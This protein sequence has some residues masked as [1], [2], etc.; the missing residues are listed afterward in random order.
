MN[1]SGLSYMQFLLVDAFVVIYL[2]LRINQTGNWASINPLSVL[3]LNG[4]KR[5]GQLVRLLGFYSCVVATALSIAKDAIMSAQ[6]FDDVDLCRESVYLRRPVTPLDAGQLPGIKTGLLLWDLSSGL[7]LLALGCL[8]CGWAY[9]LQRILGKDGILNSGARKLMLAWGLAGLV[10]AIAVHF[11]VHR[12]DNTAKARSVSRLAT[13]VLFLLTLTLLVWIVLRVRR[14]LR[15]QVNRPFVHCLSMQVLAFTNDSA[16]LLAVVVFVRSMALLIFDISYLTPQQV[17]VKTLSSS[18]VFVGIGTLASSLISACI[19]N[20][21]FPQRLAFLAD[22]CAK[23]STEKGHDARLAFF[24]HSPSEDVMHRAFNMEPSLSVT[25]H[26]SSRKSRSR[27]PTTAS[28]AVEKFLPRSASRDMK[29]DQSF[30]TQDDVANYLEHIPYIDRNA[31]ENSYFAM[32]PWVQP[33]TKVLSPHTSLSP[34]DFASSQPSAQSLQRLDPMVRS[35]AE[36][37]AM[38]PEDKRASV[39]SDR[40]S[41]LGHADQPN[42]SWV[43]RRSQIASAYVP[44]S[45]SNIALAQST[46]G[47]NDSGLTNGALSND[48]QL[49]GPSLH[50][51]PLGDAPASR[52]DS[53]ILSY[54][55]PDNSLPLFRNVLKSQRTSSFVSDDYQYEPSSGPQHLSRNNPFEANSSPLALRP[56]PTAVYIA[57]PGVSEAGDGSE[58]VDDGLGGGSKMQEGPVL[59]HRGSKASLRRKNTIERRKRLEAMDSAAERSLDSSANSSQD[60]VSMTRQLSEPGEESGKS[61]AVD[62]KFISK[63]SR[64]S[65]F[66]SKA[67]TPPTSVP[68]SRQLP[69]EPQRDSST[70]ST[71]SWGNRSKHESEIS[72][73]DVALRLPHSVRGPDAQSIAASIRLHQL[74]TSP[75]TSFKHSLSSI[76]SFQ[77]SNDVFMSLS[78]MHT[79]GGN[80]SFYTP[81]ASLAQLHPGDV[82]ELRPS[83]APSTMRNQQRHTLSEKTSSELIAQGSASADKLRR[84]QTLRKALDTDAAAIESSIQAPTEEETAGALISALPTPN[85]MSFSEERVLL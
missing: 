64:M 50:A 4:D 51:E 6:E 46:T 55:R 36:P 52:P 77:D 14:I 79:A 62:K 17:A 8:L 5:N 70:I 53:I 66:T 67:P 85:H 84:A 40:D 43:S 30:T 45:S 78:S 15:Q 25:H 69:L 37:V 38:S 9:P 82:S 16:T 57:S 29:L 65:A 26:D 73:D 76:S 83:T 18:S 68:G 1:L 23:I 47:L 21:M 19:V 41:A 61:G 39:F 58:E 48:T 49:S 42:A 33:V 13:S 20:V 60:S 74:P 63:K 54:M 11:G 35:A 44:L 7:H 72:V 2:F 27:A 3:R 81:E 59:I 31:R 56:A 28:L 22:V 24:D 75:V 32:G 34:N 71:I 80:D 10:I 12:G